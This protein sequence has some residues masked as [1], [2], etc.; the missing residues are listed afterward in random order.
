MR[1]P[2]CD[3]CRPGGQAAAIDRALRGGRHVDR[4]LGVNEERPPVSE[5]APTDGV[6]SEHNVFGT[7]TGKMVDVCEGESMP[8]R[9]GWLYMA[10]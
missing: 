6:Y 9:A 1:L 2:G 10:A 8:P 4:S 5:I 7:P 3:P